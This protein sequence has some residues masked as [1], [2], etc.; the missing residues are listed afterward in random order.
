MIIK[1]QR[2]GTIG[3]LS[4]SGSFVGRSDVSDFEQAVFGLL[5]EEIV[6]IVLDLSELKF[7][8]SAGLGAMISAMVSVGRREGALKLAAIHGDVS[9][10]IRSMHLDQVFE[11][12][13]TVDQA[14][15]SVGKR[16]RD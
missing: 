16:A 5:K 3:I 12:Y 1:D 13:D 4:L 8:A 2:R 6:C 10:T 7:I 9:R 14:E 15:A 11:V